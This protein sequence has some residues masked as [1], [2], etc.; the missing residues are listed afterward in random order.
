MLA[1]KEQRFIMPVLPLI[2]HVIGYYITTVHQENSKPEDSKLSS[3]SEQEITNQL[4]EVCRFSQ[5]WKYRIQSGTCYHYSFYFVE[6]K[7]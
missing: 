5:D 3:I 1:H 7:R 6:R 2:M 4:K